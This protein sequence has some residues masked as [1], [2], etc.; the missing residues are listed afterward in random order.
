MAYDKAQALRGCRLVQ[1]MY[2]VARDWIEADR[3]E[4][5]VYAWDQAAL[6]AEG[7]TRHT[8][9]VWGRSLA[10]RR[11]FGPRRPGQPHMYQWVEEW[12]PLVVAGSPAG[13]DTLYVGV[14]GTL[15]RRDWDTNM[16]FSKIRRVLGGID[17]GQVHQGFFKTY[18]S[19]SPR[20]VEQLTQLLAQAPGIRRVVVV[21]HSLGGALATL[22]GASLAIDPWRQAAGI[23]EVTVYTLASPR[24]G[25]RSFVDA[26]AALPALDFYNIQNTHDIV[27][28]LPFED[29]GYEH[30]GRVL[31]FSEGQGDLL[32]WHD[33]KLYREAVELDRVTV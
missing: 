22:L 30:A 15:L 2:A 21:G 11:K 7:F 28:K 17:L 5:N 13:D 3:P 6:A 20:L 31:Q 16:N 32:A 24:V 1:L 26:V 18:E 23:E 14:R 25:D 33:L 8:S 4:D 9:L 29:L 12:A 10:W 27:P 19:C